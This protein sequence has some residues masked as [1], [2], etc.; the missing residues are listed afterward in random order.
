MAIV[1]AILCFA[2]QVLLN[3]RYRH[4]IIRLAAGPLHRALFVHRSEKLPEHSRSAPTLHIAV[5]KLSV[6]FSDGIIHVSD[7][8]FCLLTL[9]LLQPN[10]TQ[11]LTFLSS[12]TCPTLRFAQIPGAQACYYTV[13]RNPLLFESIF[14][15]S[16]RKPNILSFL[17]YSSLV[18]SRRS[19]SKARLRLWT[20]KWA[21]YAWGTT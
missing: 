10:R 19:I 11:Y 15:F 20:R 12:S 5:C 9:E 16:N 17:F 6:E 21:R 7:E 13:V 8:R 14:G 2:Q 1:L 4:N 18:A 3:Q